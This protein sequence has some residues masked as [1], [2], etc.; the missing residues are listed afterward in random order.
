MDTVK[1]LFGVMFLGV[2]IYLLQPLVPPAMGMLLWAGLAIVSG[3]WVFTLKA[4]D[5]GPAHAA[6]RAP[7]LIAVVY[8]ILLL[9]GVASGGTDPLQPLGAMRARDR[10]RRWREVG[11]R[12][13][14]PRV[15]NH[16]IPRASCRRVSRRRAPR[17]RR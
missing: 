13:I 8:G 2:A 17:A 11:G 3:Y 16:Q 1:S 7:G 12:G 10:R 14:R 9:I 4:R 5:G 6:V 15:R